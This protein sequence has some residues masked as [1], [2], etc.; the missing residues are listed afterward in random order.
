MLQIYDLIHSQPFSHKGIIQRKKT[1]G[2]THCCQ[3]LSIFWNWYFQQDHVD[4]SAS[5]DRN[6]S[7]EQTDCCTFLA[8]Q[9]CCLSRSLEIYFAA[10]G[11]LPILPGSLEMILWFAELLSSLLTMTSLTRKVF[12]APGFF[13]WNKRHCSRYYYVNDKLS[14]FN[15]AIVP[16]SKRMSLGIIT[17]AERMWGKTRINTYTIN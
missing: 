1:A 8:P 15:N 16:V 7:G 9:F 17:F 11:E 13:R 3:T 6:L 5:F 10:N 4:A 12:A 14:G 2:R